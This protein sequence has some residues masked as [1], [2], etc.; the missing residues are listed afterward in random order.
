[1]TKRR[2]ITKVGKIAIATFLA[3]AITYNHIKSVFLGPNSDSKRRAMFYLAIGSIFVYNSCGDKLEYAFNNTYNK[4]DQFF[5]NK[6][7]SKVEYLEEKLNKKEIQ[8]EHIKDSLGT[9]LNSQNSAVIQELKNFENYDDKINKPIENYSIDNDAHKDRGSSYNYNYKTTKPNSTQ[10]IYWHV[11][12]K[13]ETL[14]LIAEQYLGEAQLYKDLAKLNE[15]EDSE[16][17]HIGQP[18]IISETPHSKLK[19]K[20]NL[21]TDKIPENLEFI[22]RGE[23]IYD[24]AASIKKSNSYEEFTNKK[25]I[26]DIAYDLIQYNNSMNN[27]ISYK[28]QELKKSIVYIPENR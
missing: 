15:I 11:T 26:T 28:K 25:D 8:L 18:I 4:A 24:L 7:K 16:L 13:G 10:Q 1:L 5:K 27:K 3:G 6:E 19:N 17:I 14:S 12:K 20:E 23:T 2:K 22:T 21:R 9:I